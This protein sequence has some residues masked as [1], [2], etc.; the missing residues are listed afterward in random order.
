M[1]FHKL[2]LEARV[3]SLEG[4]ALGL[5]LVMGD[6]QAPRTSPLGFTIPVIRRRRHTFRQ[7]RRMA[8]LASLFIRGSLTDKA[9]GGGEDESSLL[10]SLDCARRVRATITDALDVVQ[11][12]RL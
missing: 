12:R 11:D 2:Y 7:T 9:D 4:L 5:L 8:H 3:L 6:P 1:T 10:P